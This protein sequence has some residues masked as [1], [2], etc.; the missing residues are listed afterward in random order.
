MR[1]TRRHGDEIIEHDIE[2]PR[3]APRTAIEAAAR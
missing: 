1:A 2:W 3:V